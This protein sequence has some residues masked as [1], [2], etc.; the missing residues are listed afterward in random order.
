MLRVP[1]GGRDGPVVILAAGAKA[2]LACITT[3][4]LAVAVFCGLLLRTGTGGGGISDLSASSSLLFTGSSSGFVVDRGDKTSPPGAGV[5]IGS[6]EERRT[7]LSACDPPK[8][9]RT[10][11]H[12]ASMR[13]M[14]PGP[15]LRL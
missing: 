9:L 14:A 12:Q 1:S 10:A 6:G 4:S 7:E 13:A 3:G 8:E 11:P 5:G 2:P 15:F